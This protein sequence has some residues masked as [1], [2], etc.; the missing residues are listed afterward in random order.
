[1]HTSPGRSGKLEKW[2]S[3]P[4]LKACEK[5]LICSDNAA[6]TKTKSDGD[7]NSQGN[8]SYANSNCKPEVLNSQS[9]FTTPPSLSCCHDKV[10]TIITSPPML[11]FSVSVIFFHFAFSSFVCL[12]YVFVYTAGS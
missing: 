7:V 4:P 9:P 1:M 11:D 6:T 12:L 5:S 2:L 8:N 3:S 10:T